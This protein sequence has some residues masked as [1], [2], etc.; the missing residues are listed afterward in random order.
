[1]LHYTA[2]LVLTL[3]VVCSKHDLR[4]IHSPQRR[5]HTEKSTRC[6]QHDM[7]FCFFVFDATMAAILC[8][9]MIH[10]I[11]FI[12]FVVL[13]IQCVKVRNIVVHAS[14]TSISRSRAVLTLRGR[15]KYTSNVDGRSFLSVYKHTNARFC[16]LCVRRGESSTL[17]AVSHL[18][19][20]RTNI[21]TSNDT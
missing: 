21:Q 18:Y 20:G 19:E 5:R 16:V 12:R 15:I 11:H 9:C 10:L 6:N 13:R 4:H 8:S 3:F 14:R 7:S 2:T 1:M 17:W